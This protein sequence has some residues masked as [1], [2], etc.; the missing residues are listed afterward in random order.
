M[1]W[2]RKPLARTVQYNRM[3]PPPPSGRIRAVRHPV[4][5]GEP[6]RPHP[7]HATAFRVAGQALRGGMHGSALGAVHYVGSDKTSQFGQ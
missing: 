4:K 7:G 1:A 2:R 6:N 5:A 3:A